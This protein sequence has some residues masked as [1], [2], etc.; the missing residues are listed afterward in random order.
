[1]TFC[2]ICCTAECVQYHGFDSYKHVTSDCRPWGQSVYI[3][4]C[5]SCGLV[6]RPVTSDWIYQCDRIYR[7]YD[8]YSQSE[9]TEQLVFD[10]TNHRGVE[11]SMVILS[12]FSDQYSV[13]HP[14]TWLDFGCGGGQLLQTCAQIFPMAELVGVDRGE[15]NRERVENVENATFHSALDDVEMKFDVIT[16]FHV[17]EHLERPLAL[18][19]S[20]KEKLKRNGVLLVQIPNFLANPFDLL[21][22]DHL[23]FFTKATLTKLIEKS[24]FE[25]I[26]IHDDWVSKEITCICSNGNSKEST[27]ITDSRLRNQ[28]QDQLSCQES[29]LSNIRNE[30]LEKSKN[31]KVQIFGSSIGACWLATELGLT[32]VDCFV[33]QD[34]NRWDSSLLG[35]E[36]NNPLTTSLENVVYPL[37]KQ[38]KDRVSAIVNE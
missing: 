27:E 2:C 28:V 17:L 7:T 26:G 31:K 5:P 14:D 1:M 22:Y 34:Q 18:L 23:M 35:K 29:Y 10:N 37:D 13:F 25:V 16:M 19:R 8:A 6:Q 24:G 20:L 38:T 21:I 3:G 15:N 9:N 12:K 30:G 32:S 33:D 36:I 4:Y 11:R